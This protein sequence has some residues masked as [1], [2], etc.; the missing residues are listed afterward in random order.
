MIGG[1]SRRTVGIDIASEGPWRKRGL[2][3][4]RMDHPGI[5]L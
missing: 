1:D 4:A 3:P 5:E 2:A